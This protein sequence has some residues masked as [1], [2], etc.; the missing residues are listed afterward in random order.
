MVWAVD[1]NQLKEA[2]GSKNEKLHRLLVRKFKR[3]ITDI[4]EMFEDRIRRGR[5]GT[6]EVLKQIIDGTI[7]RGTRGGIYFYAFELLVQHFGKPLDNS[8]VYPWRYPEF[9]SVDA[10]LKKLRVP[11]KMEQLFLGISLP[12]KLPLPEDF[13]LTGW[14]DEATVQ[15]VAAVFEPLKPIGKD[16]QTRKVV[17]AVRGWFV[18]ASVLECGLVSYYH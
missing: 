4:D 13:P 7:P 11:F 15:K 2:A 5:P 12:V 10:A 6:A 14:V 18:E 8:A 1:T 3:D 17:E 9:R 16:A